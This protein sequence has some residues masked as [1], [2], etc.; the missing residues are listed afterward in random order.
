[1]SRE[2]GIYPTSNLPVQYLGRGSDGRTPMYSQTDLVVQ[3]SF[4]MSSG[5]SLQLSFNV[6]N[7]FNQDTSV[8]RYSTYQKVNG[9]N[10]ASEPNFFS[11]KETLAGDIVSQG[12]V[13]DPRFLMDNAFQAPLVARFGVKFLF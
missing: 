11:G 2:L 6:L 10:I 3:H 1:V 9:V 8:G 5:R 4:S 12:V 13:K 7:L